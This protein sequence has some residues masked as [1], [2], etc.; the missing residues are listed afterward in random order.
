MRHFLTG[1]DMELERVSRTGTGSGTRQS[2]AAAQRNL[3]SSAPALLVASDRPALPLWIP[4]S[5]ARPRNDGLRE[6]DFDL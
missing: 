5:A 1:A 4:G 2:G 6:N 3:E